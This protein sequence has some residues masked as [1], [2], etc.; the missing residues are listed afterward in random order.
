MKGKT[1]NPSGRPK[2]TPNKVTI[3]LR[4]RIADFLA[5]RWDTIESDFDQL[6]PKDR[7]QFFE[8]LL[9]YSLPKAQP[10]IEKPEVEG[11]DT[12]IMGV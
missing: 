12:I 6:E 11:W 8:K 10:V 2:G 5:D 7:L 3:D 4:T 1:N 9:Q